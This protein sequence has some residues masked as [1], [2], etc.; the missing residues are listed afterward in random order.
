M[1]LYT[2]VCRTYCPTNDASRVRSVPRNDRKLEAASSYAPSTLRKDLVVPM[3]AL[4]RIADTRCASPNAT[5]FGSA[6][7]LTG[8][9]PWRWS[10]C[11][12]HEGPVSADSRTGLCS[13]TG[14]P[15]GNG[16][17]KPETRA[18]FS[19]ALAD[20]GRR[21]PRYSVS[22]AAKPRKVK[23]YSHG[24]RKRAGRTRTSNQ[25]VMKWYDPVCG[26]TY[27]GLHGIVCE[28]AVTVRSLDPAPATISVVQIR[29]F[30][31]SGS[32]R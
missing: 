3:I 18:A 28:S 21:R 5:L 25:V 16:S 1:R 23:D 20:S 15:P 8:S 6:N 13:R 9:S 24:A 7:L 30:L 4:I 31:R 11:R 19:A 10:D 27:H 29:W 26:T 22:A 17:A 14:I 32:A 2:C 12:G